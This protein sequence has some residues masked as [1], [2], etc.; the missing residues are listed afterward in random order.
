MEIAI[1]SGKGGTGK[2]SITAVFATLAKNLVLADC[3]VDAANLYLLFNPRHDEV[4]PHDGG[5]KALINP[6]K[7]LQCGLCKTHCHF[8]A[9]AFT[10]GKLKVNPTLCEG[11]HLCQR[12]CPVNAISMVP[13]RSSKRYSGTFRY[14]RMVYGRLAPAEENSGKLVSEVRK[15][16]KELSAQHNL[17]MVLLDGPPGIG[18]TAISTITGTDRVVV[19]TEPTISGL[20]DLR[21]AVQMVKKF[22]I[23]T[24]VVI[25]KA[26]LNPAIAD[27]IASYCEHENLTLAGRLPF[28]PQVVQAM[29]NRQSIVEHDKDLPVSRE[30]ARIWA[31]VSQS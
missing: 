27:T 17:P 14:G 23:A 19:V 31:L 1:I 5:Q 28:D 8:E 4:T 10:N 13:G 22:G 26:D 18:C 21:R 6:N 11:C 7:C 15:A 3:D 29:V 20:H 24:W 30:I 9:I 25:N 12:I 16:A 2:S